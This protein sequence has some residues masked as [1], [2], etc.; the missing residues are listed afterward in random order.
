MLEA[1]TSE[2][3]EEVKHSQ[4]NDQQSQLHVAR[5]GTDQSDKLQ[6]EQIDQTDQERNPLKPFNVW[7]AIRL[8]VQRPLGEWLGMT[9]FTFVG[10]STNLAV[11]TSSNQA[12]TMETQYWAWGLATMMG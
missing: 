11:I 7:A 4:Q 1:G 8:R 2:E 5:S 12:G 9:V 3:E 10:I 6:Q